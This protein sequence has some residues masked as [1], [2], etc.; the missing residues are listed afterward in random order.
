MEN[1]IHMLT[2]VADFLVA[3]TCV[4]ILCVATISTNGLKQAFHFVKL[5]NISKF[6][7][8]EI[9]LEYFVNL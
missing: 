2:V 6:K 3:K 4:V 9:K 1:V 7:L 5:L 8:P